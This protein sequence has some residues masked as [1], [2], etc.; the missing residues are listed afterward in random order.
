[1]TGYARFLADIGN[2]RGALENLL[3]ARKHSPKDPRIYETIAYA[4]RTSGLLQGARLALAKRDQLLGLSRFEAGYTENT[5]LYLGDLDTFEAVLGPGSDESADSFR[6]FYRGYARLLRG[7]RPAAE[8]FFARAC[9]HGS[10]I[11]QFETLARVYLLGVRGE[12]SAALVLLRKLWMARVP[13]RVPDGEYTFKLAEAFSFL[14]SQEEAMDVAN[15]AFAQGFGCTQWY[16]Q[17]PFLSGIRG[18]L[19]WDALLQHL[20]ERQTLTEKIFPEDHFRF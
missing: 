9:F 13:L 5:Y 2:Q 18:T 10:G 11:L 16:E 3:A 6:D 7:D 12:T 17:S 14:G 4:A 1:V 15:R 20:R 19:R 8:R